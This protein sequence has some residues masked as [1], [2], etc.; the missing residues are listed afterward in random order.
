M[1]SRVHVESGLVP[2]GDTLA[3]L[4]ETVG[5]GVAVV[6]GVVT[7]LEES[8]EDVGVGWGGLGRRWRNL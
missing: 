8:F 6:G 3:E 4:G 5:L 7:L 1:G 2:V